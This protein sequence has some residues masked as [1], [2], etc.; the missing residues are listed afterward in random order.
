MV[1]RF[2]NNQNL[3]GRK[4]L[5]NS[6]KGKYMWLRAKQQKHLFKKI[7]TCL[8]EIFCFLLFI[9]CSLSSYWANCVQFSMQINSVPI[10]F[11]P[12]FY[13]FPSRRVLF[14]QSCNQILVSFTS[15]PL[16]LLFL[17][18]STVEMKE[19]VLSTKTVNLNRQRG[20]SSSLS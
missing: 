16:R 2:K 14:F 13:L 4:N 8:V 3:G 20:Y 11:I 9:K 7:H 10:H 19:N 15:L 6:V 18:F 17:N 12:R 1:S 5:V